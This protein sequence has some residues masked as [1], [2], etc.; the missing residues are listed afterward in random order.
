MLGTMP[1]FIYF[2]NLLCRIFSKSLDQ[3][4]FA[5]GNRDSITVPNENLEYFIWHHC[6]TP[7]WKSMVLFYSLLCACFENGSHEKRS[8]TIKLSTRRKRYIA[9]SSSS[10]LGEMKQCTLEDTWG[11]RGTRSATRLPV[12]V[13]PGRGVFN[14]MKE[15]WVRKKLSRGSDLECN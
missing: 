12:L 6:H 1:P 2:K 13:N 11:I 5:Y 4:N 14:W 8:R 10:T 3:Y 15:M 7:L 9:A